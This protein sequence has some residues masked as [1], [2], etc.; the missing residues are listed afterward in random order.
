MLR[1]ERS[2]VV[3]VRG[4]GGV[5]GHDDGDT[6]GA[7]DVVRPRHDGDLRNFGMPSQHVFGFFGIDD[8]AAA[9]VAVARS[10]E[11]PEAPSFVDHALVV[12]VYPAVA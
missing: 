9:R 6:D 2:Q 11:Q 3:E 7:H 8:G 5:T 10:P 12:G 1:A 4:I